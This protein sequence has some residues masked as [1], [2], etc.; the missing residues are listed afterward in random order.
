VKLGEQEG[1][2]VELLRGSRPAK[3]AC[4]NCTRT[5]PAGFSIG[6]GTQ[7]SEP[8]GWTVTFSHG[9]VSAVASDLDLTVEG[10]A[11]SR[12][13]ASLSRGLRD[14]TVRSCGA[15]SELVH[16]SASGTTVIVYGRG[17]FQRVLVSRTPIPCGVA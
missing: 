1:A 6:Y 9:V 16:R 4:Q 7:G 5:F 11:A 14:F 13:F 8:A 15:R 17:S 10:A 3:P 2:V 12:G